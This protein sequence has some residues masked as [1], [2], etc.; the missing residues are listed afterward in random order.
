MAIAKAERFDP[1]TEFVRWLMD[2]VELDWDEELVSGDQRID[3]QH[4]HLF[5]L[6]NRL[7]AARDREI[8]VEETMETLFELR[9]HAL[10]HF[11]EEEGLLLRH[12]VPNAA[13]HI[14]SHNEFRN[15]LRRYEE[16][17]A[18][19][20]ADHLG[21]ML[22]EIEAW[23]RGHVGNEDKRALAFLRDAS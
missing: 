15:A 7:V 21:G 3:D 20:D 19:A 4:K 16:E 14:E 11:A 12:D 6:T 2:W 13:E 10:A 5:E 9:R 22:D 18:T 17:L 23:V 8:P 1:H